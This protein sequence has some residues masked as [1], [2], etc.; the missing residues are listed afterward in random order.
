MKELRITVVDAI[1][2][3]SAAEWDAC[4]NPAH[5]FSKQLQHTRHSAP[6]VSERA[7]Q[8]VVQSS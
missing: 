4:A 2:E 1:D 7:G 5:D 6:A 8:A 3:V